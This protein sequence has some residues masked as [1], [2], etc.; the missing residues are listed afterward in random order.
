VV[1]FKNIRDREKVLSM[2]PWHFR[3]DLIAMK[4][5]WDEPRE[6][7]REECRIQLWVQIHNAPLAATYD[8]GCD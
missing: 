6:Q 3:Q 4:L 1:K 7:D 2:G 5:L 8:K